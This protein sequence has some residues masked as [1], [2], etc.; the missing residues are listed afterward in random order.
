MTDVLQDE[1]VRWYFELPFSARV[2]IYITVLGTIFLPYLYNIYY[3]FNVELIN[4]LFSVLLLF[5]R[6]YND[7]YIFDIE[8]PKRMG[9]GR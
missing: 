1:F 2:V 6:D 8:I 9:H 5:S 4:L 3:Y 7:D